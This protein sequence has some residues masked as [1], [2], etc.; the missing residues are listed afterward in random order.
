[1]IFY[2]SIFS[3][4]NISNYL[5]E[6]FNINILK[7]MSLSVLILLSG[8]RFYVGT[9]Y[10]SYV[11]MFR[12]INI[13]NIFNLKEIGYLTI[14]LIPKRLGFNVQIVFLL[15]SLI[16]LLFIYYGIKNQTNYYFWAWFFYL[17]F[18]FYM[19]SMNSVRQSIAVAIFFYAIKYIKNNNLTKFLIFVFIASLFH[20]SVFI[21]VPIYFIS[22][23]K[24]P[25]F[26]MLL[27]IIVFFI[28]N[29]LNIFI[30]FIKKVA[31]LIGG[32][33]GNYVRLGY[34]YESDGTGLMRLFF[35]LVVIFLIIHREKLIKKSK[36]NLLYLNIAFIYVL[37]DLFFGDYNMALRLLLYFRIFLILLLP[38]MLYIFKKE[39]RAFVKVSF[40]LL[41]TLVFIKSIYVSNFVP[42][43]FNL[44]I[45]SN[46]F[47]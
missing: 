33:Y 12:Y 36:V 24:I 27:S 29:Q 7:K 26:F 32:R 15:S 21:A 44:D 38:E 35:L 11:N 3:I 39:Q 4:V 31:L 16:T 43:D 17:S 22:K 19:Q 34:D 45:F 14:N 18:G 23:V 46:I 13:N 25:K 30:D 6:H 1:M 42:Y 20:M 40:V 37:G 5:G 47:Y 41:F 10:P 9:D 8:F 28:G 2:I